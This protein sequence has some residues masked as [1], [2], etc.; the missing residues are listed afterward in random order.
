MVSVTIKL[1]LF[2]VLLKYYI[3]IYMNKKDLNVILGENLK[4]YRTFKGLSQVSLAGIL[5]ISP[6]FISDIEAGKRW[7]SS[8]TM[9]NLAAALGVEAYEFL[10]PPQ[11]KGDELSAFI[12]SY[13]E[14]ATAAA[15]EAVVR[16]LDALRKQ[17]VD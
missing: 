11:P 4:K 2:S 15:S 8:E 16:S 3:L 5:E 7:V 12:K 9:G 13:T 14:K 1:L 10:K 6:N 17:Y